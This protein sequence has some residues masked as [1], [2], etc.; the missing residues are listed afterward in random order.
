MLNNLVNIGA[1]YTL[2]I[3]INLM[4]MPVVPALLEG[5]KILKGTLIMSNEMS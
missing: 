3:L 1:K 5:V 4:G 2:L